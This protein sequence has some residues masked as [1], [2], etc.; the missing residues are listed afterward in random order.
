MIIWSLLLLQ[1]KRSFAIGVGKVV[2]VNRCLVFFSFPSMQ[3]DAFTV[4]FFLALRV[5][6]PSILSQP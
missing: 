6:L 3:S 1:S 5:L 2:V 4:L